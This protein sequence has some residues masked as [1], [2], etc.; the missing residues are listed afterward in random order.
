MDYLF[1]NDGIKVSPR[2]PQGELAFGP[3]GLD[4]SWSL[5]AGHPC[6]GGRDAGC[7]GVWE[8]GEALFPVLLRRR[9]APLSLSSC[10]PSPS[11]SPVLAVLSVRLA[12]LGNGHREWTWLPC[13][14]G[15]GG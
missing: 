9:M 8:C 2:S 15:V 10:L 5:S 11:H 13:V 7:G 3:G 1:T 14:P 6:Q 4:S 12:A